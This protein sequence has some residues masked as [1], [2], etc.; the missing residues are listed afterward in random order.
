MR[1]QPEGCPPRETAEALPPGLERI[2]SKCLEND[3]ELRYR[4]ASE[5][6]RR[7]SAI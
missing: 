4:H 2:V 1:W 5:I 7:S 6:V 3:P